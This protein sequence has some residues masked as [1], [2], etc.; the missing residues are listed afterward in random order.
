MAAIV[1]VSQPSLNVNKNSWL[2]LQLG[3][4]PLLA[5]AACLFYPPPPTYKT[6]AEVEQGLWQQIKQLQKTPPSAAELARVRAQ[7]VASE[8]YAQ[9]SITSQATQIGMLETVGLSWRIQEQDLAALE[10]I[11]PADIQAAAQ[12]YFTNTRL[13]TAYIYPEEARP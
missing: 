6:I 2:S 12:K 11:T 10:T 3:I 1:H 7:V 8:V 4:T 13:T 5:E 9:D